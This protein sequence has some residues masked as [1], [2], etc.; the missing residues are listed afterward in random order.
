MGA[1]LDDCNYRGQIDDLIRLDKDILDFDTAAGHKTQPDKTMWL[2][3]DPVQRA[4]LQRTCMN[5][6]YPNCPTAIEIVGF[7]ISVSRKLICRF[8]TKRAFKAQEAARQADMAPLSR[9]CK[10]KVVA[11]KVIPTAIYGMQWAAPSIAAANALRT[12]TVACTWDRSSK[13]RCV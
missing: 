6:V 11:T 2:L 5:G 8:A 13:M 9:K 3:T 1:Y 4:A 7:V 12:K 10:T